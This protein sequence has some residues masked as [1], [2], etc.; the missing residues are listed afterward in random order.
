MQIDELR[1]PG[2]ELRVRKK[3]FAEEDACRRRRLQKKTLAEL[4]Y[5]YQVNL[6]FYSDRDKSLITSAIARGVVGNQGGIA[7]Q[8]PEPPSSAVVKQARM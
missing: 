7:K 2:A 1:K 8:W 6:T 4:E 3:T 5:F